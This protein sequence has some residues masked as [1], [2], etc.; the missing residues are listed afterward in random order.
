MSL[1]LNSFL[2]QIL[3]CLQKIGGAAEVAP[4]IIVGAE[5]EDVLA[6]SGEAEIT[7]DDGENAFFGKHRK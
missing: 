3:R 4:V 2:L 5:G 7:R 6:L 1:L